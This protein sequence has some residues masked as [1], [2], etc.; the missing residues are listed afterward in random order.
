MAKLSSERR[1]LG[2]RTSDWLMPVLLWAIALSGL[3]AARHFYMRAQYAESMNQTLREQ[4]RLLEKEPTI[5]PK[6]SK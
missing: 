5:K 3:L 6:K 4:V 2:R 1:Q